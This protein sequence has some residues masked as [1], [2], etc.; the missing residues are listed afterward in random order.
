MKGAGQM[1]RAWLG[2]KGQA[3]TAQTAS[4]LRMAAPRGV[5]ISEVYPNSSAAKA[6]LLRGDVVLAVN[7]AEVNDEA[8]IRY[9]TATVPP[10][11]QIRIDILR[12]TGSRTLTA[13]AEAPPRSP[14]AD[15]R[16]LQGR[17]PFDGVQVANL[18][19][20][21]ADDVGFDPFVR[22]VYIKAM[23]SSGIAAQIGFR[24][25]DIVRSVNGQTINTSADLERVMKMPAQG[26]L[27]GVERGGQLMQI[28]V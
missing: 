28:R 27:I 18:S 2:V 9:Q 19:P 24:P 17:I 26:W 20:A 14:G 1:V 3:V 13:R 10:G 15:P 11:G 7:G 12:D 25:G 22:G 6:G 4:S 21:E 23:S 16:V 5:I 8:A